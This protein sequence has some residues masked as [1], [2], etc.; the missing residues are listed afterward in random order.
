VKVWD[1]AEK[2]RELC[3]RGA[4]T[5]DHAT[6]IIPPLEALGQGKGLLLR[7]GGDDG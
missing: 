1:M 5:A 3:R 2:F 7:T 6:V 4:R